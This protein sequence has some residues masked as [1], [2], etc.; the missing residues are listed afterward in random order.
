M[1]NG[2]S[3]ATRGTRLGEF[4]II[5]RYFARLQPTPRLSLCATTP[6][7]SEPPESH[8]LVLSCDTIIGGVHF[9]KR[10]A[11]QRRPT[12]RLAVS[13]SDLAAKGARP[14]VYLLSV[15][16]PGTSRRPGLRLSPRA[17]RRHKRGRDRAC[18]RRRRNTPG[19]LTITVTAIGLVP[20]GHAV[21]RR[22][23]WPATVSM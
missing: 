5:A 21:L 20:Q 14:Y 13:V 9:L 1:V 16:L 18:R 6:P 19:P 10:P 12:R 4:E 17:Y 23:A 2:S 7:C 8:E 22:G 15:A 3:G 11:G